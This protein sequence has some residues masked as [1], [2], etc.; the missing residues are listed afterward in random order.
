M[1]LLIEKL[2][3]QAKEYAKGFNHQHEV[4]E[5]KFAE[6]I[7]SECIDIVGAGGEFASR[8]K[9]VEKLQEHFGVH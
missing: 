7:V 3:E 8:P 5:R 4:F 1:N 2:A 9:L 6:L